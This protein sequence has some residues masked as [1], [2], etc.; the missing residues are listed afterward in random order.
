MLENSTKP[1]PVHAAAGGKSQALVDF[2][3]FEERDFIPSAIPLL[4]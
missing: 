3:E 4:R 1:D 2:S